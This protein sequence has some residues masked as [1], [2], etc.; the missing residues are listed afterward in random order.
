MYGAAGRATVYRHTVAGSH[1]AGL[2]QGGINMCY[3]LPGWARVYIGNSVLTRH[4]PHN[5]DIRF[6]GGLLQGGARFFYFSVQ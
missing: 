3:I 4:V 1:G 2:G 5:T 6:T